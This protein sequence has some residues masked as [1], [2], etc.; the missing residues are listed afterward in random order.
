MTQQEVW[1]LVLLNE[2]LLKQQVRMYLPR[3]R[4]AELDDAYSDV[5]LLRCQSIM[6]RYSLDYISPKSNATVLPITFLCKNVRW[7]AFEWVLDR[8]YKKKVPTVSLDIAASRSSSG[9][10]L[11]AGATR[12]ELTVPCAADQ[13]LQVDMI[14]C[15]LPELDQQLIRW[16]FLRGNDDAEVAD[17]LGIRRGEAKRLR[18][19]ALEKAQG[20]ADGLRG[21][22][23][24]WASYGGL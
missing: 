23:I 19:L 4:R 2:R 21:D 1:N 11:D 12:S 14:L 15:Q 17:H 18:E 9:D 22:G 6:A 8:K 20:I 24:N 16:S 5:V 10:E 13:G 3:H 7:Y